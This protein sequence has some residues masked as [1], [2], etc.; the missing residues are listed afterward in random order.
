MPAAA[1][2]RAH[3]DGWGAD[4]HDLH[5]VYHCVYHYVYH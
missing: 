5:Y 3:I 1:F 4:Y 2:H